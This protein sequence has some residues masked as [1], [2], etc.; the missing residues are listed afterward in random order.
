MD[1]ANVKKIK[2]EMWKKLKI[3]MGQKNFKFL[4]YGGLNGSHRIVDKC[5]RAKF[6]LT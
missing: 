1:K 3:K 4:D 5:A 2:D 6:I